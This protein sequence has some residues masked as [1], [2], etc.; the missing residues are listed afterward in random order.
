MINIQCC[1]S[2]IKEHLALLAKKPHREFSKGVAQG[3]ATF[4]L[5]S[6]N[7]SVKVTVAPCEKYS[8]EG[9]VA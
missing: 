7:C 9:C 6:K 4:K 5:L 2:T 1:H 8:Y 3:E